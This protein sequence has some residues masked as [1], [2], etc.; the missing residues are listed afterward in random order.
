MEKNKKFVLAASGIFISF[1]FFGIIQEKIT[2]T[3]YVNPDGSTE[4]FSYSMSL[5]F[6]YCTTNYILCSIILRIFKVEDS[7]SQIYYCVT[8]LIYFLAMICS[9]L[10]LQ[11]IS[12]PTQVIAKSC[13]PIP[14]MIFGVL[15]GKKSYS[16]KKYIFIGMIVIGV[17]LF[18]YKE[19]KDEKGSVKHK[20][21][22]GINATYIM[23]GSNSKFH[24]SFK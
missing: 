19:K 3:Q 12:Y 18:M 23:I 20:E 4:N 14:V 2:K 22:E 6:T 16:Y 15:L 11:F 24:V 13:K 9:N 21:S 7:T 17:I 8:G 5:V 1:F 10:A